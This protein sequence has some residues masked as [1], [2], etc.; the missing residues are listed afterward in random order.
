MFIPNN[1]FRA[2]LLGGIVIFLAPVFVSAQTL[3]IHVIDVG[4]GSSEL[5]IGPNGTT[6][7][8]D[9]GTSDKGYWNV[10]PYLNAE[11][12]GPQRLDY[13]IASHD[14][15]DHYGGLISVLNSGYTA[16]HTYHCG[17]NSSFGRG[18][19]IP[20]G[21][22]IDLGN[23]ATA[24]CVG[25]N[26]EFI[27]GSSG[28][29]SD[30]NRSVCLLIDYGGFQ[31]I[32]AGDLESNEIWLSLALYNAGYL[33]EENGVDVI[34]VNHH[35]SAGSS[36]ATYVN[37]LKHELAVIN[38][39]TGY[40]HPRRDAVDR[41]RGKAYYSNGGSGTGVTW[42]GCGDNVYRTTWVADWKDPD[43]A[44][45]SECPTLKNMVI[46]YDGGSDH[47]YELYGDWTNYFNQGTPFYREFKIDE[48]LPPTP[49]PAPAP[50]PAA[51]DV[52]IN[53]ILAKV[54]LGDD[55][56]SNNDGYRS[57]WEDEFVEFV[58]RSSAAIDL[59][60][61]TVSD[62]SYVRYI[63]PDPTWLPSGGGLVL[64]GGGNPT[65]DFGE[66]IVL[67]ASLQSTYGLGLNDDG[68]TVTL[69][70]DSQIYDR[71]TYGEQTRCSISRRAGDLTGEFVPHDKILPR[72]PRLFSPGK[73]SNLQA[74]EALPMPTPVPSRTPPPTPGQLAKPILSSGDYDGDGTADIAVFRSGSGLWAVRGVTRAYWGRDGDVPVS[75]D[76]DADGTTD[77]GAYRPNTGYWFIK[78]LTRVYWGKSGDIP[79]PFQPNPS[80][81][82]AIGIYRPSAGLWA[83]R[84]IT[85]AYWGK[86][87]GS[88]I[89]LPED[90][91]GDGTTEIGCYRPSTGY[92]F[93][94][95]LTKVYWGKPG[96][97]IPVPFRLNPSSACAIGVYRPSAGLWAV[98]GV[99]RAYWGKARGND[100]PTPGD[101]VGSGVDSVGCYRPSTGYWFIKDLTKVYWGKPGAD[102][103]VPF[104]L[105]PSS[106]CAIG[107]Y[108][109]SAGLWAVRGV[110]R[111][112]WGKARGNDIPTPGDYVGSGVDS[113]GCYRPS[114][115]Y[116]FIKDL[117]KVF[118]GKPGADIP[119]TR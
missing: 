32:T 90:Y 38:G 57:S 54:P 7:L 93:I 45:E 42:T 94:K 12:G 111:A 101:Y 60:G 81:A 67:T 83:V 119:V 118:W 3:E 85:R 66:A 92:W 23:G 65:G 95:D 51:G 88:D 71:V 37:S 70:R 115:G 110:T 58:N 34:H 72:F 28:W 89:P 82:C 108:R 62:S 13:M 47:Y 19:K 79:V 17:V 10:V 26:A 114:T 64:F 25:R 9:G 104:R 22:E 52:V 44:P 36:S 20:L 103:P 69:A 116:W 96:A 2:L 112:Y 109:P 77:I 6:I 68:D 39:G 55:G 56:D 98:R 24:T 76:Y 100:I 102:I 4:Q 97:D 35:G 86:A 31:Y 107:V 8:I 18:T 105:N 117:T 14:D 21:L 113:V 50:T 16:E 27:D 11:L 49:T 1:R 48:D 33:E 106:A 78:D 5:I 53:E 75:G 73:D 61:C 46:T 91:S 29:T 99:T 87:G 74:F 80:S 40:G 43:R 63:F 84:G 59:G 41:L 15:G 30:N